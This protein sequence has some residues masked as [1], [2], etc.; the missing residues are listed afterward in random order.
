MARDRVSKIHSAIKAGKEEVMNRGITQFEAE[1]ISG[2]E[3]LVWIACLFG[4]VTICLFTCSG[5]SALSG[6]TGA[7]SIDSSLNG[8]G[9]KVERLNDGATS[10]TIKQQQKQYYP[11][12]EK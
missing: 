5:C 6:K 12:L 8:L 9:F 10:V 3:W 11:T 1:R 2:K 7:L 4:L